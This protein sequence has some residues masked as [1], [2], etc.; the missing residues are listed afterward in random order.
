MRYHYICKDCEET[1][2]QKMGRGLLQEDLEEHVIFETEHAIRPSKKELAK[3]CICPRCNGSNTEKTFI[4][5]APIGY[6]K[7]K[8]YHDVPGRRRDLL[9]HTLEVDDPYS[10]MR[11]IGEAD[12]LKK[13]IRK[14]NQHDPSS[15]YFPPESGS[16]PKDGG[17]DE[18]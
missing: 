12:D 8:G 14:G 7:C 11:E 17:G 4:G 2:I 18:V 10:H 16:K 3:A 5:V 9:V 13:K 6:V 15:T 1:T